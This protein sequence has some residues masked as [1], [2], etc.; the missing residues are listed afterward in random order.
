M[1]FGPG[2]HRSSR[3]LKQSYCPTSC[4]MCCLGALTVARGKWAD[5]SGGKTV[6]MFN[7]RVYELWA[8]V[9]FVLMSRVIDACAAVSRGTQRSGCS[10]AAHQAAVH[11][12]NRLHRLSDLTDVFLLCTSIMEEVLETG[13][14]LSRWGVGRSE[15]VVYSEEEQNGCATF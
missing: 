10:A 13:N 3:L 7:P 1:L 9:Q 12:T 15:L 14:F 5:A 6:T 11:T 4:D 2:H 8:L